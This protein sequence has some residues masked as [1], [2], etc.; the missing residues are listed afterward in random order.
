MFAVVQIQCLVSRM[1]LDLPP[2]Y[3]KF[4]L[5]DAFVKPKLT[6]SKPHR[7]V[8]ATVPPSIRHA[9][10]QACPAPHFVVPDLV[11]SLSIRALLRC[12]QR[13]EI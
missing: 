13:T 9:T 3:R 8:L 6:M 1:T 4:P 11:W 12:C 7:H 2:R 10:R 5:F